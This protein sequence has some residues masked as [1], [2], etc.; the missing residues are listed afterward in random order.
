MDRLIELHLHLDGS[1]RPETVW[2]IAAK[3][4]I[5]VP[6][7][8][9]EEVRYMMEVPDNCRSLNEYLERFELP[10]KV[11]QKAEH[12]ERVSFELVEDLAKEGIEYAE[13]RYAPLQSVRE[14]LS[15]R[16]R[17]SVV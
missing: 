4:R 12:I 6:A 15:L 17:K 8:S 16:D 1:L 9:L 14:G 11:L 2:D 10:L 3:D 7:K 13:I 5:A